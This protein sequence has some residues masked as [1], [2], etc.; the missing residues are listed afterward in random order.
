MRRFG[1]EDQDAGEGKAENGEMSS[2]LEDL[3][4]LL[5]SRPEVPLRV[6]ELVGEAHADDGADHGV[7]TGGRQAEPP[8]AEVPENGGNEER[9][10]HGEASA[11]AHLEDELDG[12]Q[13][14]DAK[15]TVP[16]DKRTPVRLQIPDQTT[17]ILGSS[18]WV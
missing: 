16:E 4:D 10:D 2:S 11:G 14:D 7:R 8:G 6:H 1:D 13:R 17:A 9:E 15:A 3:D 5:Q 18:E 12:E